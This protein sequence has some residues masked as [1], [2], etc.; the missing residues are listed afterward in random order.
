MSASAA[1]KGA[2]WKPA[3]RSRARCIV[4]L[5]AAAGAGWAAT[6]VN[7]EWPTTAGRRVTSGEGGEAREVPRC[8]R[9][10]GFWGMCGFAEG[11]VGVGGGR[12]GVA[13]GGGGEG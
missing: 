9:N 11:S 7:G 6:G 3:L 4:P 8:A 1:K 2:G 13:R 5:Q 12:G 10:D